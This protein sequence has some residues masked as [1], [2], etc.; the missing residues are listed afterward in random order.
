[1]HCV[2][3][4]VPLVTPATFFCLVAWKQFPVTRRNRNPVNRNHLGF[5]LQIGLFCEHISEM[6]P[7]KIGT[8]LLGSEMPVPIPPSRTVPLAVLIAQSVPACTRCELTCR[9]PGSA[10]ARMHASA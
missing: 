7:T 9:D 4:S 2:S 5:G 1:M 8:L 3:Q 10:E 6:R